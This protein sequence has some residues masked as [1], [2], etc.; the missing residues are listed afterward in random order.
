MQQ[1]TEKADL[2]ELVESQAERLAD[3]ED[4]YQLDM[5]DIEYTVSRDKVVGLELVMT[6]GGPRVTVE[7]LAGM[8]CGTGHNATV[9]VHYESERMTQFGEEL[10]R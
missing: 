6:V 10:A 8:V 9:T 4:P 3:I 5:L 7:P 2:F 1:K